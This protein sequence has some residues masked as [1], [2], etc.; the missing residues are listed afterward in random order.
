[1]EE[2]GVADVVNIY[3]NP[4]NVQDIVLASDIYLS[5]SL[6]EGT[7]NSIMEAL[8]WSLPVV[9]TNVGDNNHLIK[10]GENGYLHEIA[11]AESMA[12]SLSIL[13]QSAELRNEFGRNSNKNL[14]D[15]YSM[16]IFEKRYLDLINIV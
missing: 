1:V 2:F 7:S 14:R 13:L 12:E 4:K 11:D 3:I 16:E 8:N 10:E 6:F 5:T 9:A 15:N